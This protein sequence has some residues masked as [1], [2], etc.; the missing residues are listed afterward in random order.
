MRP[1][2]L[3]VLLITPAF[4]DDAPKIVLPAGFTIQESTIGQT[5]TYGDP[6]QYSGASITKSPGAPVLADFK[7]MT[8]YVSDGITACTGSCLR[9]WQPVAA[10][11]TAAPH[12]DW[13]VLRRDDGTPQWAY[14]GHALYTFVKD[15]KA[16]DTKGDGLSQWHAARP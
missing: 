8:V 4:A 15:V 12:G 16:G 14:K 5:I 6:R 2:A 3:V 1:L 13:S 7:G 10:P 11:L 9:D